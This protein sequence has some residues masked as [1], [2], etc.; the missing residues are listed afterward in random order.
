MPPRADEHRSS[1]GWIIEPVGGNFP[2]LGLA[3]WL[4]AVWAGKSRTMFGDLQPYWE[5]EAKQ[6]E[7]R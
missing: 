6:W 4:G 7:E 1:K 5:S 3:K 2:V